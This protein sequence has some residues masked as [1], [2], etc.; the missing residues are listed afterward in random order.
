[1]TVW[2]EYI[3]NE[4][5]KIGELAK[6]TG[7]TKRTIDYYTNLGILKAERS[8]SNYRFYDLQSI[9]C[10]H[11]IEAMKSRGMSLQEIKNYFNQ[12]NLDQSEINFQELRLQMQTLQNDVASLLEK[13]EHEEQSKRDFIKS[14]VSTE[15]VALMQS[16]ILLIT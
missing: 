10:I 3:G 9:E 16:L 4:K 5:L 11:E 15:S 1:M 2:R 13:I 8:S 12:A 7:I 14:K 6:V